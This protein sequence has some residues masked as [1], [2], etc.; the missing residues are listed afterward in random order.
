MII[1]KGGEIVRDIPMFTTQNGVASLILKEIVYK[2]NAYIR[3]QD[4]MAPEKLLKECVDFCV[5]A[6]AEHI[7]ATGHGSLEEYPIHSVIVELRCSRESLGETDAALFP[8]LQETFE[9]WRNI[10]NEKMSGVPNAATIRLSD[11]EKILQSGSAYFIHREGTLLG[12]GKAAGNHIDAV[13]STIPGSGAD[14]LRA[15][16]NALSDDD[17]ILE[18]ALENLS[19]MRLYQSLGF[20]KSREISRWYSVK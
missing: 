5:A 1:R 7:F 14:V 9:T 11:R 18:C 2:Q 4:S 17:V 12:I 3:L 20:V 8:V 10:Y 19:A 15:L 13:A 16:C 6:G